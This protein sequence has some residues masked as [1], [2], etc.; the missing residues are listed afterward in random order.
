MRRAFLFL[1]LVIAVAASLFGT[2][3]P[4]ATAAERLHVDVRFDHVDS[5]IE[6]RLVE[7]GLEIQLAVPEFGRWQGWQPRDRLDELRAVTG[8]I[9]VSTPLY[10]T[11]S[12]GDVLTEGDELLNAASARNR[13]DVDGSGVRVA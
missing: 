2:G 4:T 9:S 7:A 12:A 10:A 6:A 13:F 1:A 11:L 8:V 5:G 3:N